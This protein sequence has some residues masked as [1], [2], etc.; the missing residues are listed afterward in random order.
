MRT[1][2]N[3][4][5]V[6]LGGALLSLMWFVVGI[7]C[8]FTVFFLPVGLQC[9]KFSG[10]FLW[11]FGKEINY[12]SSSGSFLINLIWLVIFGWELAGVSLIIGLLWCIT[13]VGVPF[14]IQ[15][16]KFSKLAFFPFGSRVV[17]G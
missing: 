7:I 8:C 2:V 3:I 13:I 17:T 1:L 15:F 4:L 10:F 12:S 16:I 11:P 5:W 6:L 9:F 14:G